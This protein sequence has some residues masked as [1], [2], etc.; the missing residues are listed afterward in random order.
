MAAIFRNENPIVRPARIEPRSMPVP[1]AERRFNEKM[2]VSGPAATVRDGRHADDQLV[3]AGHRV[4]VK[5]ELV[6][7]P[8]DLGMPQTK[9]NTVSMIHGS[10]DWSI[11]AVVY[12]RFADF[13]TWGGPPRSRFSPVSKSG[14]EARCREC[15]RRPSRRR[16]ATGRG[17]WK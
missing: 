16:R 12:S 8:A 2:A 1:V 11:S 7:G 9:M 5:E 4:F 6:Q 15:L 13:A 3:K 14:G 10:Q 17:N